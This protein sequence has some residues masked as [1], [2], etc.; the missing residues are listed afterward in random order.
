MWSRWKQRLSVTTI[1]HVQV[2]VQCNISKENV[3]DAIEYFRSKYVLYTLLME[4]SV[5]H[6]GTLGIR[7]F[8]AV[9]RCVTT[10]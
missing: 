6:P 1:H 8:N 5:Y 9:F 7:M 4:I 2:L 3:T 10:I